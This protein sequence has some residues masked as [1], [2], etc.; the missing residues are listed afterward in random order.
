MAC[1]FDLL[2]SVCLL[3]TRTFLQRSP[4][5]SV[6]RFTRSE[7][8][9]NGGISAADERAGRGPAC[10]LAGESLRDEK[11]PRLYGRGLA[12]PAWTEA[13]FPAGLFV[14][15]GARPRIRFFP[16]GNRAGFVVVHLVVH[17]DAV[18]ADDLLAH[19]CVLVVTQTL[20]DP[21]EIVRGHLSKGRTAR[22]HRT[23]EKQRKD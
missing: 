16:H 3:Q 12:A 20:V 2:V 19:P 18:L 13:L 4:E 10:R 21:P 1:S 5:A 7:D 14:T 6:K 11:K 22:H 23:G 9:S 15:G 17:A 8:F